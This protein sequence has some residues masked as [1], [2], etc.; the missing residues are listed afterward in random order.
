MLKKNPADAGRGQGSSNVV[1]WPA[2][3]IDR[4][5]L[6]TALPQSL[7]ARRFASRFNL[8]PSTAALVVELTGIGGA[9]A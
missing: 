7:A 8:P 2:R 4:D 6:T 5:T 9:H 1:S 3:D